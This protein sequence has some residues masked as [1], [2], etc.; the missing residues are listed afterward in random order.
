MVD[1][2]NDV[3]HKQLARTGDLIGVRYRVVRWLG[4]GAQGQTY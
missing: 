1:I 3:S 2:G 4:A